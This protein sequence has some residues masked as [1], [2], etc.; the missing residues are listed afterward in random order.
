VNS[1]EPTE[2]FGP[3]PRS[4]YGAFFMD[5]YFFDQQTPL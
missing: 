5:G 3:A 2:S 4:L 1:T